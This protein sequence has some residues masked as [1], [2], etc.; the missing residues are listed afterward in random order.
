MNAINHRACV[1]ILESQGLY[2]IGKAANLSKRLAELQA[3]NPGELNVVATIVTEAYEVLE[4]ALHRLYVDQRVRGEWFQLSQ[5]DI[6][7]IT[8]TPVRDILERAM[9]LEPRFVE[10]RMEVTVSWP[11]CESWMTIQKPPRFITPQAVIDQAF[12]SEALSKILVTSFMLIFSLG[13]ESNYTQ[14]PPLNEEELQQFLRLSRRQYIEHK[15]AMERASWCHS[16]NPTPGLVQFF[17]P[18]E[19]HI[20]E[21]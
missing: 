19:F 14:T 2:K 17:F 4:R 5:S 8:T 6:E 13:W 12:E 18:F 11:Q 20:T 10:Q 9:K 3:G 7:E 21:E 16:E 1:Y 15:Q